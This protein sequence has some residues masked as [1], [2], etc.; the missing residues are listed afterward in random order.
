MHFPPNDLSTSQAASFDVWPNWCL[1][2]DSLLR[3]AGKVL[4]VSRNMGIL[5]FFWGEDIDL[6]TKYLINNTQKCTS[7][8]QS[9][10]LGVLDV[11][12]GSGRMSRPTPNPIVFR[13][14]SIRR[15]GQTATSPDWGKEPL[16]RLQ[17]LLALVMFLKRRPILPKSGYDRLRDFQ[18]ADR[19]NSVFPTESSHRLH[20]SLA[21]TRWS[22]R[23]GS[24]RVSCKLQISLL[25]NFSNSAVRVMSIYR[26][27]TASRLAISQL[28]RRNVPL[29]HSLQRATQLL[30]LSHNWERKPRYVL[31]II[32]NV[33]SIN[34]KKI[35]CNVYL[36][37][38][39]LNFRLIQRLL[40]VEESE[41]VIPW[42]LWK[43]TLSTA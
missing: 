43:L 39:P 37:A 26:S 8:T 16:K 19:C 33:A 10:L 31:V 6:L 15:H 24:Q 9:A 25:Q 18:T 36:S 29:C 17:L 40:S 35:D 22:V 12:I 41:T 7:L 3:Y 38:A 20:N 28:Y 1:S 14:L 4:P 5:E 27:R 11:K 23:E 34:V 30:V 42:V 32:E 13:L 2:V 21:L